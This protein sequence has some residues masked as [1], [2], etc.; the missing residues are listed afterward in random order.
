[1]KRLNWN[2]D[3]A[4]YATQLES[5]LTEAYEKVRMNT[6]RQLDHQTEL[7]NKKVHGKPYEVGSHVWVLFPQVPRGKSKKLYRPWSGPFVVVKRLSNMT[8]RV[9]DCN[10]RRKRMVVHFNRLKPYRVQTTV[11]VKAKDKPPQD[12]T[13]PHHHFGA[14]LELV[15]DECDGDVVLTYREDPPQDS[16]ADSEP[17]V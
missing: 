5:T 4:Q 6:T 11:K 13:Q 2:R 17:N 10:N 8:Y 9:Q 12:N 16:G 14:E 7:Y 1:M 3:R 15:G